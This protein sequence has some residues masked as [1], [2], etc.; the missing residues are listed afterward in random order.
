MD[1]LTKLLERDGPVLSAWTSWHDTMYLDG[2]AQT[3]FDAITLDMQHGMHTE[4]SV[5]RAIQVLAPRG[6]PVVVRIPVGR[7]NFASKALDAGAH[8]IIAPM[9]NSVEDARQLVAFTKY[10]PTG[11]RSF[12][13]TQAVNVLRAGSAADYVTTADRHTKVFAM[14]ETRQALDAM[15]EIVAMDGIDGIFCGPSDLSISM[16]GNV[17]PAPYGDETIGT[18]EQMAKRARDEGKLSAAFCATPAM[19]DTANGFGYD[20]IALGFDASYIGQGANTMIGQ[21]GFR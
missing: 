4:D 17:V 19:A 2:L 12:G 18:V 6:K 8:G 16:T 3:G 9:I 5:I 21:L 10:P 13:P 11:E 1:R 14:I 7:F 20:F 15:D